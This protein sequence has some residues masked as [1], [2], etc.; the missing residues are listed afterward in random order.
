[1]ERD[2]ASQGFAPAAF[3]VV[4]AANVI[5]ATRRVA[6]S[7]G[8]AR[9]L[10][11]DDGLLLLYE[12]TGRR[13]FATLTFGLLDGWW[14][15]DDTS[16][17]MQNSP[18]LDP[19]AWRNVLSEAGYAVGKVLGEPGAADINQF[20][21]SIIISRK[22]GVWAGA[23][24]D[25]SAKGLTDAGTFVEPDRSGSGM[26]GDAEGSGPVLD[27]IESTVTR[28][29]ATVLDM[30]IDQVRA[31]KVMSFSDFGA[32]SIVSAELTSAINSA[33]GI[34]L[35][36]TAIFNNPAIDVLSRHILEQ[37]GVEMPT[38]LGLRLGPA[39][40]MQRTSVNHQPLSME[41]ALRRLESGDL[42]VDEA[43]R[44]TAVPGGVP[45]ARS[46]P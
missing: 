26:T 29:V 35:K 13:D 17:R 21:Q 1:I 46:A 11:A 7:I 41:D 23:A 16:L 34:D 4:I 12:M 20:E 43:L 27:Y 28:C 6:H 19:I 22:N 42:D 9:D 24:G 39:R 18:L 45:W 2:V 31:G 37:Y 14:V 40:A 32:D 15:A 38:R 44:L 8:H 10:L 5:H 36:T 33:L 30:T 25:A 3:D